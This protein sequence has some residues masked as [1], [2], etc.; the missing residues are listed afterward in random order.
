M[1]RT[2]KAPEELA[3]ERQQTMGFLPVKLPINKLLVAYG[4][5]S[6]VK[7]VVHNKESAQQQAIDLLNYGLELGWPDDKRWL[8]I[9]NQLK[10]GTIRNASGRL[11][12]DERPG[13]QTV[14]SLIKTDTVG[15]VLVRAVD[16]LFRDETM[17]APVVF[18]N[19]C[20]QHHVLILTLDG[21]YYDFNNP[22]RDD[23]NRFIL[24]ATRA[25]DYTE[26]HV[27]GV[28]LKN[29]E[30][31][32]LRGEF[33]GH[34][35]PTGLMLDDER[36]H[37]I[38]NPL[39]GPVVARLL[40]RYRELD[41]NF[42]QL[43]R[44]VAGKPIFPE[45]PEDILKRTGP[46]YLTKVEGGYTVHTWV[47]LRDILINV[48]LIGHIRYDGRLIKNTHAPIVDEAD[49]WYAFDRLSPTDVEGIPQQHKN[50]VRYSK[51]GRDPH[52]ALLD[53][54]RSNG[55]AVITSPQ[56]DV[57][58]FQRANQAAGA[59]YAIR[60][61]RV[62]FDQFVT[63]IRVPDLDR[64][65][66]ERMLEQLT[67]TG[68][69]YHQLEGFATHNPDGEESP[70]P[71]ATLNPASTYGK[72]QE[73]LQTPATSLVGVDEAIVQARKEHARLTRDYEVNFDLMSD[74]ELRDNRMVRAQLAKDLAAL[75]KKKDEAR[76][77][78]QD[79]S[80]INALMQDAYAVWP[81]WDLERQR[82]FVRLVTHA[83]VLEELPG[84]WLILTVKW[85]PFPS[86]SFTDVALI[87]RQ[88]AGKMW[89]EQEER[90]LRRNYRNASRSELLEK[91]PYRTWQAIT[92]HAN[93]LKL[94]RLNRWNDAKDVPV[95]LSLTDEHMI[96]TYGL[97]LEQ[98]EPLCCWWLNA[99]SAWQKVELN[100]ERVF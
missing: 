38:E 41:G 35:V 98:Q 95:W 44:E 67:P 7:Q 27:K 46:I 8:F 87:Y 54:T 32:A 2:F 10:D 34:G 56:G 36:K 70:T 62:A 83:I 25:K 82:R 93:T 43:R 45:L 72:L 91:L 47:G 11:R 1:S 9:E 92:S 50:T 26:K 58:V 40:K 80:D 48:A 13:L 68:E 16:R 20:K 22:E 15:A 37:Y 88:N 75:E 51:Q 84:D 57:Y 28:M 89:T 53:G 29:R 94:E 14:T 78:A 42:G 66:T 39:W 74:K 21:D 76:A 12:I 69:L 73:M 64:L 90:L 65:F 33:S 85:K 60:N 96:E 81:K 31:K 97:A 100:E 71:V 6:T 86:A 61:Y 30:R 5:Q 3:Q 99:P 52:T 63:S 19:I 18:A 23:L 77:T 17:V 59:A 49:F 79:L 24:E 4:R 55:Q